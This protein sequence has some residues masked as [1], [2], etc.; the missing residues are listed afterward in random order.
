MKCKICNYEF[1]AFEH[2]VIVHE[3]FDGDAF[4]CENCFFDLALNRLNC[5]SVQMDCD[6]IHYHNPN[7]DFELEQFFEQL[8]EDN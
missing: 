4:M 8:D 6:G 7:L 2:F 3:N 5:E 1:K